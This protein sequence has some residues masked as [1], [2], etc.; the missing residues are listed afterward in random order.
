MDNRVAKRYVILAEMKKNCENDM[1]KIK[2]EMDVI[3]T[4]LLD[5][6]TKAG[7]QSVNV[8]NHTLYVHRQ[9]WASAAN[10]SAQLIAALQAEGYGELV[11]PKVNS[12]SLSALVRE[13]KRDAEGM[14]ILPGSMKEAVM[15]TEKYGVRV[16]K[17]G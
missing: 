12:Q 15:V 16:R 8:D 3:E 2:E 6:F 4:K 17:A 1:E 11:E 14:P 10:G 9:L 5:N 7:I 13:F